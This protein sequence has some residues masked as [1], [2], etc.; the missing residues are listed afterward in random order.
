[1]NVRE[2]IWTQPMRGFQISVVIMCLVVCIIDGFE[3]LVMAFIAP[4]LSKAWS[5]TQVQTGYLLSAGIFGMAAGSMLIS[6]LADKIGRRRHTIICLALIVIGMSLSA[7]AQNLSWLLA[8]RAFAGLFLG[9]IVASLNVLVAEYSSDRR[10]G[11]VMGIY[12]IGFPLGA[13]LGGLISVAL[14]GAYGWRGPLWFGASLT[15]VMFVVCLAMLPE[16]VNY[17][18]EKR[19][20][21]A[22]DAYNKIGAKLGLAPASEMPPQSPYH[23]RTTVGRGMFQGIMLKRT[24][25]LWCGYAMLVS[26]FYFANSWTPKLISDATGQPMLGVRAGALVA[27]GGV[28]G[29]LLFA[30]LSVRVHP[31][32]GTVFVM[33]GGTIAFILFAN[34]FRSGPVTALSVAVLVGVF[35]NGGIAAFYAIS[36]PIYPTAIRGSAVGF[37]MAFG[38]GFSILAPIITGYIL[39][40]GVTPPTTYMGFGVIL[41][42]AGF[43]ILALHRS[44]RGANALDAMQEEWRAAS[45]AKENTAAA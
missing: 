25:F 7:M 29:A 20:A 10:R 23:A 27:A 4:T 21:G 45:E 15:A 8:A 31:R 22:L 6:P 17:L 18:I 35:A 11:T 16:S 24:I 19:P 39:A 37:M 1:M 41:I 43:S 32:L 3:I 44:Y 26:A 14:I 38:R 9:G 34:V 5:L 36:P 28:L 40:S 13:A 33:W 30:L 12:G 42:V 2:A